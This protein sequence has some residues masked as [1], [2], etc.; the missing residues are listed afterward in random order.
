MYVLNYWHSVTDYGEWKKIF[1][2]D[3]LDRQGSGVRRVVIER[4]IGQENKVVGHLEFDSLQEAETFAGRLNEI[5]NGNAS[6]IVSDTGYTLS[7][8]LEDQQLSR[9]GRRAA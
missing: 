6:S 5:W 4:P 7:E 1:D 3:P 8:I 9:S 2:R